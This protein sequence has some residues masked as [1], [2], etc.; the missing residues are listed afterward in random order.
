MV[1]EHNGTD[2]RRE[3]HLLVELNEVFA[4]LVATSTR[5][6]Q[7]TN[8]ED[9]E[10]DLEE[11]PAW[12][13]LV[14]GLDIARDDSRSGE[15]VEVGLERGVGLGEEAEDQLE[16]LRGAV[17]RARECGRSRGVEG[18]VVVAMV[19]VWGEEVDGSSRPVLPRSRARGACP[20]SDLFLNVRDG[21]LSLVLAEA[22]SSSTNG[23][24]FPQNLGVHVDHESR[25]P[26]PWA[27]ATAAAP[28]ASAPSVPAQPGE[29]RQNREGL[30]VSEVLI[31][32]SPSRNQYPETGDPRRPCGTDSLSILVPAR[33]TTLPS[34]VLPTRTPTI[35]DSGANALYHPRHRS[36]SSLPTSLNA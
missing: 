30:N 17:H 18:V 31:A 36:A 5:L 10:D 8:G 35:A 16:A 14:R 13:V 26:R 32:I 12:V 11:C 15:S 34:H 7:S 23:P 29:N 21:E 1:I 6:Q 19:V 27:P 24:S 28:L 9:D 20:T 3:A 33:S 2:R 4:R 22:S 25:R